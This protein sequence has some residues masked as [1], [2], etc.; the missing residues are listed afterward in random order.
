MNW[1]CDEFDGTG[2][3]P[4]VDRLP[5]APVLKGGV[6]TFVDLFA[7]CGGLSLGLCLAGWQ[8]MFAI[9]RAEDA[10]ETFRANFLDENSSHRFD[11]PT[12]LEAR[13]HSIEEVLDS[14]RDEVAQL[15]GKVDLIAGGPPCQ[16]FSFAGKR[17]A[18]DP[19][20]KMFQKYVHFIDNV[21]PKFLVLENVPGMNVAHTDGRGKSRKT[22]YQ[23]LIAELGRIGYEASG[24]VLDATEFGVPQRRARLIVIGVEKE[25]MAWLAS[26]R[27][28]ASHHELIAHLFDETL[29]EGRRQLA[30]FGDQAVSAKSAISDLEIG[31]EG[32]VETIEYLGKDSRSGYRQVRYRGPETRYQKWMHRGAT[33]TSMDSMRLANHR[34]EIRARFEKILKA[35]EGR[36]GVNLSPAVRESLGMLKHRT[37]PMDAEKPAPTLTT[38]PDDVLH[39]SEPRILTVR[40]YARLQSFPDWFVFQGKYTTGGALR[41]TECPRYT[42]VGNAV[43]PL[44]G[45][46][47]GASLLRLLQTHG[48]E[49]MEDNPAVAYNKTPGPAVAMAL[50]EV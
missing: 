48:S 24:S 30:C 47:I 6:P 50:E 25:S 18:S 28:L 38:L 17:R 21:R 27:S 4:G 12:W 8:G 15:S 9:E 10:F 5:L 20:N 45:R 46:A 16:G 33:V 11:W 14:K 1:K 32:R 13:A 26:A 31:C 19:R 23:E 29:Q 35:S 43:P 40:E 42:Q 3:V 49:A 37:V 36:R 34:D 44:L 41:K 39:Y 7:G 2:V 22:F